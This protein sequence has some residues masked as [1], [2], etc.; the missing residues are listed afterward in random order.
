MKRSIIILFI[1]LLTI[2][3]SAQIVTT[4]S[5]NTKSSN[6]TYLD[7]AYYWPVVDTIVPTEPVYDRNAREFI[8][9]EDTTQYPDTVV[10]RIVKK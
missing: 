3:L 1:G 6:S 10:M 7:D 4:K 2:G 5:P 8:F 9:L